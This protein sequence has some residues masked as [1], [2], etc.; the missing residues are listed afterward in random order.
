MELVSMAL[1][2]LTPKELHF[3]GAP[4]FHAIGSYGNLT[5]DDTGVRKLIFNTSLA[6][7]GCDKT[8]IE[9]VNAD[10]AKLLDSK[11]QLFAVD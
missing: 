11:R 2:M 1:S 4:I 10:I 8:E 6:I 5:K 3:V 7:E 9:G